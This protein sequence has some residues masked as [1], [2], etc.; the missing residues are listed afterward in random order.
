MQCA[1]HTPGSPDLAQ[2]RVSKAAVHEQQPEIR[3]QTKHVFVLLEFD[4]PTV[5]SPE[6]ST[7]SLHY[8]SP[9]MTGAVRRCL[10]VS[11]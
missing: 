7:S 10:F 6:H 1:I 3:R 11:G 9:F 2:E 5:V 4:R 8:F